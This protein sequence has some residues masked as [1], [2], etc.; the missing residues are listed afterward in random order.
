L[1]S[2]LSCFSWTTAFS[3]RNIP[4]LAKK[5]GYAPKHGT[6]PAILLTPK[7]YSRQY[8]F[9]E[10]NANSARIALALPRRATTRYTVALIIQP[11]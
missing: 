1:I 9:L 11:S 5:Q 6:F 2:W 3:G 10:K 7:K 8:I 4:D